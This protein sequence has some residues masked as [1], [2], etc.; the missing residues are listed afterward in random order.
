M[1]S[2]LYLL[3]ICIGLVLSGPFGVRR[4]RLCGCVLNSSGV[5][6]PSSWDITMLRKAWVWFPF[7]SDT[8]PSASSFS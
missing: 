5:L 7:G 4:R 1:D 3:L 2:V 6:R 8:S